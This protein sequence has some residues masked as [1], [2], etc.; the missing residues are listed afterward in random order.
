MFNELLQVVG[1]PYFYALVAAYWV[2]NA[3]VEAL[4]APTDTN[5]LGH[6]WAYKFLNTL[7]GNVQEAFASRINKIG[8]STK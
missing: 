7:S 8:G 1:N 6:H 5:G 3:A 2:F 4:P